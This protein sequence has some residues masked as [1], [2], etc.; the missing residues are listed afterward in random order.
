MNIKR[1]LTTLVL[2]PVLLVGVASIAAIILNSDIKDIQRVDR[3][4]LPK[5]IQDSEDFKLAPVNYHAAMIKLTYEGSFFCSAFVVSDNYAVT[6]AH[7]VV[8]SQ[9]S[10]RN[11]LI[12]VYDSLNVDTKIAASTV[13]L[14]HSMDRAIIM[15]DFRKFEKVKMADT[16]EN[17]YP[18]VS[19]NLVVCGYPGGQRLL[20]VPFRPQ[21]MSFFSILGWGPAYPGM[22]GGIVMDMDTQTAVGVI[23][24]RTRDGLTVINPVTAIGG[25]L[26]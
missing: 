14:Q 19:Q 6:A 2:G 18:S 5:F 21:A 1:I 12:D 20:C 22:S 17:F 13:A 3:D 9:G 16:T 23:S 8:D 10:M 24:A 7:C 11:D 25:L 15:G 26:R 4:D